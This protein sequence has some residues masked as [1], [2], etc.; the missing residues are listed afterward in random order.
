MPAVL[1]A[2]LNS[3]FDLLVHSLADG[4]VVVEELGQAVGMDGVGLS[5]LLGPDQ[6]TRG[7]T[8]QFI[9]GGEEPVVVHCTMNK[10]HLS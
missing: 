3:R 5:L 6:F 7:A 8:V 4:A 1:L 10:Y 2:S 9:L